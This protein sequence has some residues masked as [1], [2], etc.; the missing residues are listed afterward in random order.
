MWCALNQSQGKIFVET[1]CYNF[2]YSVWSLSTSKL[3]LT[4]VFLWYDHQVFVVLFVWPQLLWGSTPR[5]CL[6]IV[7]FL[8]CVIYFTINS[9][10]YLFWQIFVGG[11]KGIFGLPTHIFLDYVFSRNLCKELKVQE[12]SENTE[13]GFEKLVWNESVLKNDNKQVGVSRLQKGIPWFH[14]KINS[15]KAINIPRY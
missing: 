3:Y 9:S 13:N 15:E 11:W 7:I 12:L 5:S 1:G 2:F 8:C 10:F 4:F 14:W 6:F